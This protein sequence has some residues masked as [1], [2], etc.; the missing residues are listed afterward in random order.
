MM[1]GCNKVFQVMSRVWSDKAATR[2]LFLLARLRMTPGSEPVLGTNTVSGRV[3]HYIY[4]D[5][6]GRDSFQSV[7]FYAH[8]Y[9]ADR[10]KSLH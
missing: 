7:G 8:T 5:D 2:V 10:L 3:T 6:G 4:T 1:I 9:M